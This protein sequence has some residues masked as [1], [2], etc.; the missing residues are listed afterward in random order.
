MDIARVSECESLPA[1]TLKSCDG[2]A[3]FRRVVILTQ[4]YAP[5]LGAPSIRLGAIARELSRAGCDVRVLTGMPNYPTGKI[6][7]GYERRLTMRE[8]IDNVPVRRAW[9]YPAAG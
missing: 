9:L 2:A 1:L 8:V 6:H 3:T 5:E 4:Y 7:P